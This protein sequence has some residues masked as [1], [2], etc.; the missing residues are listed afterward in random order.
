MITPWGENSLRVR[1]RF[2]GDVEEE[3][4]ALLEPVVSSEAQIQIDEDG[5]R[6]SMVNGAICAQ[7]EVQ[8]WG[9]A[10]QITYRNQKGEVLLR[11]NLQWRGADEKSQG[12]Q[13]A[14]GRK[15]PSES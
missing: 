2:L 10:L 1:G 6:A 5:M 9:H 11:G 13:S 14:A 7:L 4:V 12:L 3:S 8:P 15:F